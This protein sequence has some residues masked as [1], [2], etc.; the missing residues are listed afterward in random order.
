ML[1]LLRHVSTGGIHSYEDLSKRLSISTPMLEAMLEDL[2]RLG[3]VRSVGNRCQ[4]KCD[5]CPV[6]GCS[7]MGPGQLWALTERGSRLTAGS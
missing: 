3:Y 1:D 4:D 7:I 6:G 2:A 5:T